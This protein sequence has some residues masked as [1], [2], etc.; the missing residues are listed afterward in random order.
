MRENKYYKQ[1]EENLIKIDKCKDQIAKLERENI[2]LKYNSRLCDSFNKV[3]TNYDFDKL[4]FNQK[5]TDRIRKL[6]ID[7]DDFEPPI[8]NV[9][10]YNDEH[11]CVNMSSH[12][13]VSYYVWRKPANIPKGFYFK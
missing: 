7:P 6:N 11:F 9:Y 3:Y 8:L 13:G 12:P 4:E 2:N 10:S 5:L 1:L